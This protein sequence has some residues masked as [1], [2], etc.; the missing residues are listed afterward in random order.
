MRV[1]SSVRP[2]TTP[3]I[4]AARAARF[5]GRSLITWAAATLVAPR[6][7]PCGRA[8]LVQ[9]AAERTL[10]LLRVDVVVRGAR[11]ATGGARLLVANHVSWLD[12]YALNAIAGARYVAKAEVARWPLAGGIARGFRTI[13]LRRG[14]L[15]DAAR[16]KDVVAAA[17][18]E[19]DRVVVF[20]EGT[21]TDGAAVGRFH[22]A[23]FEAAVDAGATVQAV[24]IRYRRADGT[25]DGAAAFVGDMTFLASLRRVLG[26]PAITVELTF[27]PPLRATGRTRRELVRLTHGFVSLA[28][29]APMVRARPLR[30]AA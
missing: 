15:R 1:D 5:V 13:F 8:R 20:P 11:P 6:L 19:G 18:R 10:R 9:R 23:L 27:G 4:R 24:A 30:R 21:T 3:A 2:E 14:S 28:L 22:A 16:V 25:R 12:V 17:L 7:D 26:R 29:V